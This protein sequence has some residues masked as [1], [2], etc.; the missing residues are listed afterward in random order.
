MTGAYI[1][2]TMDAENVPG[3]HTG[4][5]VD[6]DGGQIAGNGRSERV[7]VEEKVVEEVAVEAQVDV[8]N[9]GP[10]SNVPLEGQA[11][12][13]CRSSTQLQHRSGDIRPLVPLERLL[14]DDPP[15][16][17]PL[18]YI[19]WATRKHGLFLGTSIVTGFLSLGWGLVIVILTATGASQ[20]LM[21]EEDGPVPER[22][23][24]A[25]IAA[26]CVTG[27]ALL[28]CM[29]SDPGV[30]PATII[31][32]GDRLKVTEEATRKAGKEAWKACE[33]YDKLYRDS[34]HSWHRGVDNDVEMGAVMPG[35]G[36]NGEGDYKLNAPPTCTLI[37]VLCV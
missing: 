1:E 13:T 29:F 4:Q 27:I 14:K 32:V 12:V 8:E 5:A 15:R 36:T 19:G 18:A 31:P 20:V 33:R 17:G 10:V 22:L 30:I 26:A 3:N 28:V 25:F 37:A 6:D 7:V 34:A 35:G 21:D 9:N 2:C 24:I 16:D 11:L 23:Y